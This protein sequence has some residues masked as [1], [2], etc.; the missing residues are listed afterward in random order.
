MLVKGATGRDELKCQTVEVSQMYNRC[1]RLVSGQNTS[2]T[3]ISNWWFLL[4]I[5]LLKNDVLQ[6]IKIKSYYTTCQFGAELKSYPYINALRTAHIY[7][8][9]RED[10]VVTPGDI[11]YVCVDSVF[12]ITPVTC[13]QQLRGCVAISVRDN[14]GSVVHS[15]SL[16]LCAELIFLG[17][18]KIHL[19]FLS[20]LDYEMTQVV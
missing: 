16:K 2:S 15:A 18:T 11:A 14:H 13:E 9:V 5:V 3:G 19:H 10:H 8:S 6:S 20:C 4:F 17:N 12:S 1:I 7:L